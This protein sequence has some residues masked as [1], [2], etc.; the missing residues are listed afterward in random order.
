MW[1]TNLPPQQKPAAP[2]AENPLCFKSLISGFAS[3]NAFS[4]KTEQKTSDSEI[5]TQMRNRYLPPKLIK[6]VTESQLTGRWSFNQTSIGLLV[7]LTSKGSPWKKSG[8][9]TKNPAAAI[10]SAS[11]LYNIQEAGISFQERIHHYE[12][13][14]NLYSNNLTRH[15]TVEIRHGKSTYLKLGAWYPAINRNVYKWEDCSGD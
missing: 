1:K 8:T 11:F 4:Y 12:L 13:T 7:L 10:L 3:S 9:A 14:T 6:K 5:S 2:T 15:I